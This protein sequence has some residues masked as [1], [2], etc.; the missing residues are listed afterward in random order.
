MVSSQPTSTQFPSAARQWVSY[1][2]SSFRA[3][4]RVWLI[5][6][7]IAVILGAIFVR[8]SLQNDLPLPSF[9]PPYPSVTHLIAG[10]LC[11]PVFLLLLMEVVAFIYGSML[12]IALALLGGLPFSGQKFRDNVLTITSTVRLRSLQL[13][14]FRTPGER[15]QS[16]RR[17]SR[18]ARKGATPLFLDFFARGYEMFPRINKFGWRLILLVAA[19][20][21]VINLLVAVFFFGQI[22]AWF[23]IMLLDL[24]LIVGYLA[25][26]VAEVRTLSLA[27]PLGLHGGLSPAEARARQAELRRQH[28]LQLRYFSRYF[29]KRLWPTFAFASL[30]MLVL[31]KLHILLSLLL[32]PM[33]DLIRLYFPAPH[34]PTYAES[35][36]YLPPGFF[37]GGVLLGILCC[38]SYGVIATVV[39]AVSLAEKTTEPEPAQLVDNRFVT[40]WRTVRPGVITFAGLLLL[41][42]GI[43]F[44]VLQNRA[45]ALCYAAYSGSAQQVETL[46]YRWHNPT[47]RG[48]YHARLKLRNLWI[49]QWPCVITTTGDDT[50]PS[51]FLSP[52]LHLAIAR[53]D[54]ALVRLLIEQG[55]DVNEHDFAGRCPLDIAVTTSGPRQQAILETLYARQARANDTDR[56]GNS[57][58]HLAAACADAD[59]VRNLLAHGARIDQ[60]NHQE[61]TPV[62]IAILADNGPALDVL[63]NQAPDEVKTIDRNGS[64][65]LLMAAALLR[66]SAVQ[67]LIT[68]GAKVQLRNSA[69]ETAL[70]LAAAA[71][72]N[73]RESDASIA[74]IQH[75]LAA[76][77]MIDQSSQ[78]GKTALHVATTGKVARFL[79]SRHAGVSVQAKDGSTPLHEAAAAGRLEVIDALLAAHADINAHDFL[80]DTPY[81][82]ALSMK[83]LNTAEYLR[84][85]GAR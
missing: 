26:I 20:P 39:A 16:K 38:L 23:P 3:M 65:L 27:I 51:W 21:L 61:D 76:G 41:A 68:H 70:H 74:V 13:L 15:A 19:G 73:D 47:A 35:L 46:L 8:V 58:L 49:G 7:G 40:S 69:G 82:R 78:N 55:A 63:L 2:I 66:P 53:G 50:A 75:L 33:I 18:L 54:F 34:L 64:S 67:A 24:V 1:V 36:V 25:M 4:K 72:R 45:D 57:P 59:V 83:Q 32:N 6:S 37:I 84:K 77:A 14:L 9:Q 43:Y 48:T 17:R 52:P 44:R 80:T 81:I 42:G 71:P 28:P 79:L 62:R 10:S 31:L 85:H 12:S 30:G 56:L 60:P 11:L 22:L 29:V 5:Y